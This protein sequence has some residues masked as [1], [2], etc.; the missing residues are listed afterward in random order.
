[1]KPRTVW[2]SPGVP[3][4]H[5]DVPQAAW[6]A[7][8][9]RILNGQS[10]H[11]GQNKHTGH[12]FHIVPVVGLAVGV[13]VEFSRQTET[14]LGAWVRPQPLALLLRDPRDRARRVW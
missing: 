3:R 10:V 11:Q 1:M 5:P 8:V 14:I 13:Q 12:E 4:H 7:A 2:T 9:R 6:G